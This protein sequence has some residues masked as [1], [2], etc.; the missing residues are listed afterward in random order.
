M[1]KFLLKKEVKEFITSFKCL[2][3]VFMASIAPFLYFKVNNNYL[4]GWFHMLLTQMIVG[5]FLFDSYRMDIKNGGIQFFI[6]IRANFMMYYFVK[7]V[8][9][10]IPIL[11]PIFINIEQWCSVLK[12]YEF[13]WYFMSLVYCGAL[14]FILQIFSKGEEIATAFIVTILMAIILFLIYLSPIYLRFIEVIVLDVL[15]LFVCVKLYNS[16]IFRKQI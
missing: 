7:Y 13:I 8:F 9:L 16:V 4:S 14:M 11:V 3:V 15:L 2:F 6:N 1:I 5:Q 12:W 10:I